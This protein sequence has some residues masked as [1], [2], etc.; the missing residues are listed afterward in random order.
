M[1]A[2]IAFIRIENF[3]S[4]KNSFPEDATK[5]MISQLTFFSHNVQESAIEYIIL[6]TNGDVLKINNLDFWNV[7]S[8]ISSVQYLTKNQI[9][10]INHSPSLFKFVLERYLGP[11]RTDHSVQISQKQLY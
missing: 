8:W 9:T 10:H 11:Y 6:I 2:E 3:P 1:N 5:V 4:K 7:H